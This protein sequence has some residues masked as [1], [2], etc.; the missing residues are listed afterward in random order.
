MP[1]ELED[2]LKAFEDAFNMGGVQ[3]PAT[4]PMTTQA[5][6]TAVPK[7]PK[8]PEPVDTFTPM[9][10]Q[11]VQD[12]RFE[13]LPQEERWEFINAAMDQD[14]TL[15]GFDPQKR[16]DHLNTTIG[17]LQKEYEHEASGAGQFEEFAKTPL[18]KFISPFM[19]QH[20]QDESGQRVANVVADV[21]VLSTILLEFPRAGSQLVSDVFGGLESGAQSFKSQLEQGDYNPD[22]VRFF[23]NVSDWMNES[24]EKIPQSTRE[25]TLEK[26]AGAVAG[27]AGYLA[28]MAMVSLATGGSS[29]LPQMYLGFG[30]SQR[31]DIIDEMGVMENPEWV[32]ASAAIQTASER[33]IGPG[34]MVGKNIFRRGV[35]DTMTK[36]AG[37]G[38]KRWVGTGAGEALTEGFQNYVEKQTSEWSAGDKGWWNNLEPDEKKEVIDGMIYGGVVGLFFSAP[39]TVAKAGTE[40]RLGRIHNIL[41]TVEGL[42]PEERGAL[43]V[44]DPRSLRRL[45]TAVTE[46]QEAEIRLEEAP[47]FIKEDTAAADAFVKGTLDT[48]RY[49]EEQQAEIA[50]AEE[51]ITP[52][53]TP[54]DTAVAPAEDVGEKATKGAFHIQREANRMADVLEGRGETA[55]AAQVRK[56]ASSLQLVDAK[57]DELR[58]LA[59]VIESF[60][61]VKIQFYKSDHDL[62]I[63]GVTSDPETILVKWDST[64][65][66]VVAYKAVHEAIH[67]IARTDKIAEGALVDMVKES[68]PALVKEIQERITET[69]KTR[70]FKLS[71]ERLQSETAATIGEAHAGDIF[72]AM[73]DRALSKKDWAKQPKGVQR[74]V[75]GMWEWA[76]KLSRK[77]D[78]VASLIGKQ[79]E[80]FDP[81]KRREFA[82]M[83]DGLLGYLEGTRPAPVD[84]KTGAKPVPVPAKIKPTPSKIV[85]GEDAVKDSLED[86]GKATA[87][88]AKETKVKG[89]EAPVT[90]DAKPAPDGD[91]GRLFSFKQQAKQEIESGA[92]SIRNVPD[93]VK[94]ATWEK[95]TRNADIGGGAYENATNYL[96]SQGVTNLVWDP[97]SRSEK[98]NQSVAKEL[99]SNPADTGTMHN[100]LNVIKER[101]ARIE[102]L[103]N[104]EKAVKDGGSVSIAVNELEGDGKGRET[105]TGWQNN[106]PAKFYLAEVEEVFGNATVSGNVI[107]AVKGEDL[108]TEVEA[109]E[110]EFSVEL[111]EDFSPPISDD[112]GPI[113]PAGSRIFRIYDTETEMT[114][115]FIIRERYQGTPDHEAYVEW[116]DI[117]RGDNG[118][119]LYGDDRQTAMGI[120]RVMALRSK[121]EQAFPSAI[122]MGGLR[123]SGIRE[124]QQ[125]G[126]RD[127]YTR[128][129]IVSRAKRNARGVTI[130]PA[131]VTQDQLDE[132]HGFDE[133][134]PDPLDPT[135]VFEQSMETLDNL[136]EDRT[137]TGQM[138]DLG[139]ALDLF[140]QNDMRL[141]TEDGELEDMLRNLGL[142]DSHTEHSFDWDGEKPD[143]ESL[144]KEYGVEGLAG[145]GELIEIADG[146]YDRRT[147]WHLSKEDRSGEGLKKEFAG[148]ASA[149]QER[150]RLRAGGEKAVH[151][152]TTNTKPEV[153][154]AQSNRVLHKVTTDLKLLKTNSSEAQEIRAGVEDTDAF[155]RE[156]VK[157]G[158]DGLL[159]P[160]RGF[161]QVY[162]DITPDEISDAREL[163][164][165]ERK[166]K[167]GSIRV[168][169]GLEGKFTYEELIWL[170]E[171]GI[172]VRGMPEDI[173]LELH[174][175]IVRSLQPEKGD[176]LQTLNNFIFA[177]LSPNQPLTPNELAYAVV[178]V[179]TAEESQEWAA[180]IPWDA[181]SGEVPSIE[182]LERDDNREEAEKFIRKAFNRDEKLPI[183][184]NGQ[185]AWEA[186]PGAF[187]ELYRKFYE[188]RITQEFKLQAREEGGMGLIGTADMTNIAELNQYY[189]IDPEW[190]MMQDTDV[191]AGGMPSWH[192]YV[193]R[194]STQ[195][196]GMA[197]K[198]SSF[199]AVW[200]D[201]TEAA[202]SAIDRHMGRMFLPQLFE[203]NNDRLDWERGVVQKWNDDNKGEEVGNLDKLFLRSGGDGHFVQHLMTKL[204]VRNLALFTVRGKKPETLRR[205]IMEGNENLPEHWRNWLGAFI[206]LPENRRIQIMSDSY[207]QALEYNAREAKRLGLGLFS[208][209]WYL[210]DRYRRRLEPHEV[211]FPGTY[212]LPHLSEARI[213]EVR[214]AHKEAGYLD[215]TPEKVETGSG[216][217]I[218]L[219]R[220]RP[221]PPGDLAYWSFDEGPAHFPPSSSRTPLFNAQQVF[222]S[223]VLDPQTG[224]MWSLPDE[225]WLGFLRRKVQDK[226]FRVR[227]LQEVI[228]R[229]YGSIHDDMDAYLHEMLYHGRAAGRIEDFEKEF[230]TPLM[231]FIRKNNIDMEDF[232]EYLHAQHAPERNKH[233]R[234]VWV[235]RKVVRL[236]KEI[237]NLKSDIEY[238]EDR[239]SDAH[240]LKRRLKRKQEQ[241]RTAKATKAKDIPNAGMTSL[242]ALKI[243]EEYA[244]NEAFKEAERLF[245]KLMDQKLSILFEGD[246]INGNQLKAVSQYKYYVPLKGKNYEGDLEDLLDTMGVSTGRG[247]DIRGD[248]LGFAFGFKPGDRHTHPIIPQGVVDIEEAIIR[249]EKNRVGQAFLALVEEFPND[250]I[251]EVS[252]DVHR[253]VWDKT[254]G[255]VK[256]VKDAFANRADNVFS[257]KKDGEEFYITIKD[258]RLA[259][260]MKNIGSE[261]MGAAIKIMAGMNRF[262]AKVNT[263]LNPEFMVANFLR[264]VQT[265]GFNLSTEEYKALRSAALGNIPAAANG[266]RKAE[267]FTTE[268]D[269]SDDPWVERYNEF[270]EAGGKIGFFGYNDVLSKARAIDKQIKRAGPG[271]VNMGI[272]HAVAVGQ[273]IER[274]NTVVENATRLS[275]YVAAREAGMSKK[276]AAALARNLTVNFNKKGEAG[277]IMN[278]I[279]LFSNASVQGTFRMGHAVLRSPSVQRMVAAQVVGSFAM[280]ALNRG[281]AGDDEEDGLNYWDKLGDWHKERNLVVMIPGQGDHIKIPLPYGY[282]IFHV[283]GTEMERLVYEASQGRLEG[284]QV[285]KA[286]ANMFAAL[287]TAFNPLGGS[288]LDSKWTAAR[289]MVPSQIAPIADTLVNETYYGA[290]IHPTRSSW[291][292]SPES[293]R[294]FKNVSRLSKDLTRYLNQMTGGSEYESGWID[295]NPEVLD[296][297]VGSYAGAGAKTASRFV[298]KDVGW[299][300]KSLTGRDPGK[301]EVNDIVFLRRVYGE[302]NDATVAAVFY[303]NLDDLKQ[304]QTAYKNIDPKRRKDWREDHGWKTS[305][306]QRM[307]DAEKGIRATEDVDAKNRIRKRFNKYY[308]E[309]WESQ[310]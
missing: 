290:P 258:A 223:A 129:P 263:T 91:Q 291:D 51:A 33:L 146:T 36:L 242:D 117:E 259:S 130:D 9:L 222:P 163:L 220:V 248:E 210:W 54:E 270:V 10:K 288:S 139:V 309:A 53:V 221:A 203:T 253:R 286:A 174:K 40:A 252:K 65:P 78:L 176:T 31:R 18:A 88:K 121:I 42:T 173:H 16:F 152:Y 75:E 271:A 102:A 104:L 122:W 107:T 295:M 3:Q 24:I 100:V 215:T 300:A 80:A 108:E 84:V 69:Y 49:S 47:E 272:R 143:Y 112:A 6:I 150:A 254:T 149:G 13:A 2:A 202:I 297:I 154:V 236:T 239:G 76:R 189:Q 68:N 114:G 81:S 206:S 306:F 4:P 216:P 90:E 170:K 207:R 132:R 110:A 101:A 145:F 280:A 61:G 73:R 32:M 214:D 127:T 293:Q 276:K 1:N 182:V 192:T 27:T 247:F 134:G 87:P 234:D 205:Q 11:A 302:Q 187:R 109:I 245:R 233:Y 267:G 257:V 261:P 82:Q 43:G 26:V 255:E 72:K 137:D 229:E 15:K 22:Q 44:F 226:F 67:A 74:M 188:D 113:W 28:P 273:V 161:V 39:Q 116:V 79:P 238:A 281:I 181:P 274:G 7:P 138:A 250:D 63:N 64:A 35:K 231:V 123:I 94:A 169:G 264:D 175:K 83:M 287:M 148:T 8:P 164:P 131:K 106:Q 228:E 92:T 278:A 167:L 285:T 191:D 213:T 235:T 5:P 204:G 157:R 48:A 201:P 66:E 89:K 115:R 171:Q 227:E 52:R 120:K 241:L 159:D 142:G 96:R 196:R 195:F 46:N 243:Q 178:R 118:R 58:E 166:M 256:L 183:V 25:G 19:E 199:A 156:A 71:P 34:S 105:K 86:R 160:A 162:R 301:L 230:V 197:T 260:A 20:L 208:S 135:A 184:K 209:Q 151:L 268:A 99:K 155:I 70:E 304:A 277:Q 29:I 12:E 218:H 251:Y 57:A 172:D 190:F 14:E 133:D 17:G 284:K 237:E 307:K 59:G 126:H 128:I 93:A 193:E 153:K 217:E 45:S 140:D 111:A 119:P 283:F 60:G 224:P 179:R 23:G 124:A 103:Q 147:F 97:Y 211:N 21:P 305:L 85:L 219:K 177:M 225:S 30:G 50:A 38:A 141:L 299:L 289:F 298:F 303:E 77:S 158:Y 292:H 41:Q 198:V 125:V 279:W 282:N 62:G 294:Y 165:G 275:A 186:N 296:Y 308:R 262:L 98:H 56:A 269:I 144:Q 212:K 246:L 194:L 200:Q 168:P 249:A 136:L 185:E 180:R 310:F 244:D 265:A 95:G 266:I 37:R 240:I 55:R 232:E